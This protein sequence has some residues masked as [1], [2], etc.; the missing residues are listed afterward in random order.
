MM[1]DIVQN[2][3]TKENFLT[4][5]GIS[6][7][8]FKTAFRQ[9]ETFLPYRDK[10]IISIKY[11][12]YLFICQVKMDHGNADRTS[13]SG[14]CVPP[15]GKQRDVGLSAPVFLKVQMENLA[16]FVDC[17]GVKLDTVPGLDNQFTLRPVQM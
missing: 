4:V 5:I 7:R 8:L 17:S 12:L 15:A 9:R 3:S 14:F 16:D 11:N 13:F 1:I 6:V 2:S 10:I